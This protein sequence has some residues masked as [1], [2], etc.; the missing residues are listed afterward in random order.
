[1]A[2]GNNRNLHVEA[3]LYMR[4]LRPLHENASLMLMILV[5]AYDVS[6]AQSWYYCR[7]AFESYGLAAAKIAVHYSDQKLFGI[8]YR[9]YRSYVGVVFSFMGLLLLDRYHFVLNDF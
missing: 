6:T 2:Q 7:A 4:M 8:R 1:M 3:G 5:N 9:S